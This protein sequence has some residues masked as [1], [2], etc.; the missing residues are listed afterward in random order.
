MGRNGGDGPAGLVTD[1]VTA[2]DVLLVCHDRRWSDGVTQTLRAFDLRARC[3]DSERGVEN[4]LAS[5]TLL[6]TLFDV[7]TLVAPAWLRAIERLSLADPAPAIVAWG[8][9]LTAFE[10]FQLGRH[11]V[12]SVLAQRPTPDE[13]VDVIAAAIATAPPIAPHIRARVGHESLTLAVERLRA[14]FLDQALGACGG[15]RT[16]A[17]R[18]LGVSRQAVYQSL[19]KRERAAATLA[20]PEVFARRRA[21]GATGTTSE[22][23]EP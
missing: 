14:L 10:G 8:A 1:A 16:K 11:A 17:S 4:A 13:V 9:H 18:L 7:R 22:G 20:W 2:R 15:D 3:A 23:Q 5:G 19:Q 6:A 12:R 21:L